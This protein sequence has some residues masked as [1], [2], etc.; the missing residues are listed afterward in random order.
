VVVRE[1]TSPGSMAVRVSL[2]QM[3][4]SKVE[5][6]ARR[7]SVNSCPVKLGKAGISK[8]VFSG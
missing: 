4:V 5:S 3:V 8:I 2:R 7:L 1:I 6:W